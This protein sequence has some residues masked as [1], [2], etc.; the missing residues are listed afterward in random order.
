MCPFW[1]TKGEQIK[2]GLPCLLLV[3]EALLFFRQVLFVPG[4]VIPWDLRGLH[5][6]Y[7]YL[8]SESITSGEF[9]LWDP[10]TYCGRPLYAT[11][12]AAVFYPTNAL[13]AWLGSVFGREHIFYLLEWSVVLHVALAGIFAYLLGRSL[14][15]RRSAAFF[16]AS[17]YELSGFFAAHAEHLGTVIGAAWLPLAWYAIVRWRDRPGWRPA[18]L[19]AAAFALTI[20][21]GHTPLAA[22]VIG[23]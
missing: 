6:P 3:V 22:F 13:V 15:L 2:G 14:G 5:L 23:F 1:R 17:V 7:T 21:A 19:L 10:Y 12:Q 20:L 8:Y 18:L 16:G 4:Y 11:I 9:P